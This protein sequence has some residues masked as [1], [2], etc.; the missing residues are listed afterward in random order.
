VFPPGE[1]EARRRLAAFAR[2]PRAPIG[3]YGRDRDRL[4]RA[5]TSALSPYLRFGMLSA[6]AAVVAAV[7]AGARPDR[8][9]RTGADTW[10][11][12]LVWRD[13]YLAV[14][15]HHASVLRQAFNPAFRRIAWHPA[16]GALR[17]WQEGCTGYPVVDAAMRQLAATG[18]IPNRARMIVAS[19]LAKDLLVD[20]RLGEAWFMR[21]LVD[22]DPAANNGGWQWAAGT[23]TDAAPYFRVFN[24]VLQGKR[25]DPEGAYVRRW[26]PALARVPRTMVHEPWKL[27]AAEQRTAG[28][29]IGRDYPAPIVDHRAA[30]ERAIA[31]YAAARR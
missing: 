15:W 7:D 4:D 20:W 26:I 14:L 30:R 10:L 16:A 11:S 8:R 6:R 31:A 24:P 23:G 18:W 17:A 9:P 28:L 1:E 27:P 3:R 21:Q 19:F 12:E 2:G 22:G 25:Y 29:P 5:G 13:F